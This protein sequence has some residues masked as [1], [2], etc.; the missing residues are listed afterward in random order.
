MLICV[1]LAG[2]RGTR[3]IPLT[4]I[5]PKPLLRAGDKSLLEWNMSGTA[6]FVDKFV[7][8]ISYL[9]QMI[10]DQI[11]D[12]YM[13]KPVEYVWQKNPKG[14]T[15]DAFRTAIFENPD[16]SQNQSQNQKADYLVIHADDIHGAETWQNM[17]T[18]IQNNP[19]NAYLSGKVLTD[20][21]LASSF[22]MLE[23]IPSVSATELDK[24]QKNLENQNQKIIVDCLIFNENNQILVQKRSATRRLFPNCWDL[25]GGHLESGD[26]IWSTISK[27][28]L[29]ETGLENA[30][31][32]ELMDIV[33]CQDL[34]KLT[35]DSN[36]KTQNLNSGNLILESGKVENLETQ[37][38]EKISNN[39]Q[40]VIL[41]FLVKVQGA[42]NLQLEKDKASEFRWVASDNLEFLKENRTAE[43]YIHDSVQKALTKLAKMDKNN[44]VNLQ[45]TQNL[46]SSNSESLQTHLETEIQNK[47]HSKT[48]SN[49]QNIN[50]QEFFKIVEKPDFFVSNLANIAISYFPNSVLEFIPQTLPNTG[51]EAYIND[52]FNDYSQKFPIEV[53][54]TNGSWLAITNIRDLE[55]A[56][57]ILQK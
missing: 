37:K 48:S 44:Q 22:G 4:D 7:I 51:K 15:L 38:L 42:V 56:R 28:I 31:V 3:L 52:L 55:N 41:Q 46:E 34:E 23:V 5:C 45:K 21:S 57:K 14:G 27:E 40:K 6:P 12:N 24:L 1:V 13:G 20:L 25:V 30:K 32:L 39:S 33:D 9:G 26:T 47:N 29:E 11:G 43:F 17:Q 2:G 49:L 16:N 53:V 35:F 10:I 50:I 19:K 54:P 8:V 18:K 36:L